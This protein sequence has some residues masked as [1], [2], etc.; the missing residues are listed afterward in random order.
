MRTHCSAL[1]A[2]K[3]TLNAISP[4]TDVAREAPMTKAWVLGR[5]GAG[6][7]IAPERF[8]ALGMQMSLRAG[9]CSYDRTSS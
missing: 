7:S 1:I 3:A 2:I 8:N 5:G 9:R 4:A 6:L